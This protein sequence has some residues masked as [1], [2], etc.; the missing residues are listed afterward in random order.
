MLLP[1]GWCSVNSI[2]YR[3]F[4]YNVLVCITLC[5]RLRDRLFADAKSNRIKM[6]GSCDDGFGGGEY[7][8]LIFNFRGGDKKNGSFF[9]VHF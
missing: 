9:I 8:P 3:S 6:G 7:V 1:F 2:Q 4:F 5:I